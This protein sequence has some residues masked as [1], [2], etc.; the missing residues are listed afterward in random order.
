MGQGFQ[1]GKG[2]KTTISPPAVK[3]KPKEEEVVKETCPFCSNE[4]V[5][6]K[7]HL[8]K[9]LDNPANTPK[10]ETQVLIEQEFTD[11]ERL[12]LK[13]AV[14]HWIISYRKRVLSM[15]YGKDAEEMIRFVLLYE[16]LFQKKYVE[17]KEQFLEFN[18]WIS[19]NVYGGN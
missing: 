10:V 13:N 5:N 6:L 3:L 19:K 16:K 14:R 15:Q 11:I 4:Y 2:N 1:F 17:T 8:K 12:D 9:C 7:A 18:K